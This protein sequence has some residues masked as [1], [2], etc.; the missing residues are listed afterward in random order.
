MLKNFLLLIISIFILQ[1]TLAQNHGNPELKR[2]GIRIGANFSHMDFSKGVPPSPT[3]VSWG[4]GINLGFVMLVPI[5]KKLSFQPEYL[6]SQMKGKVKNSDT[7]YKLNYIS[8]PLFLK[9]E[10]HDKIFLL[11][12]PQFDILI[13]A[14]RTVGGNFSKITHDTEERSIG[15]TAGIEFFVSKSLSVT[16]RYMQGFNHI[17]IGQRSNVQEYKF[18]LLQLSA[19]IKF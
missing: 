13:N 3:I 9:F 18:E 16:A 19:C 8:L 11:A 12:G 7:A 15:T 17:G 6:F 2:F 5:S 4:A 1:T 14:R 10:L